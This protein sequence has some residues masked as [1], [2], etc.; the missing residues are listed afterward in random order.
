MKGTDFVFD[1]V[2]LL[3]FKCHKINPN[4]GGSY[5]DTPN[6]MRNKKATINPVG[7]KDNK[8]FQ[9]TVTG[10]LN[11]KEIKKDLQRMTK[12]KDFIDRYNWEG[13]NS[14]SELEENE[15]KSYIDSSKC[16]VC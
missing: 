7:K 12:I 2:H 1:S 16:F 9:Y 5:I 11:Y 8:C 15:E 6:W 13:I 3:Y 10:P 14:P 4:R